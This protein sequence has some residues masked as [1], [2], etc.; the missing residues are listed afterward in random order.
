MDILSALRTPTRI[1]H[2]KEKI[3]QGTASYNE[4]AD[5]FCDFLQSAPAGDAY[6]QE[7]IE[8]ATW[9]LSKCDFFSINHSPILAEKLLSMSGE[10]L[11]TVYRTLPGADAEALRMQ[12]SKAR[13]ALQTAAA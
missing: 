5:A 13:E 6:Y 1:R 10:T 11:E 8:L 4:I 3:A 12:I 2:V 9:T 7:K